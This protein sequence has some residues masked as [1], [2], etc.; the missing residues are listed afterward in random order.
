MGIDTIDRLR[1]SLKTAEALAV[2]HAQEAGR[3]AAEL[4]TLRNQKHGICPACGTDIELTHAVLMK[5]HAAQAQ[6]KL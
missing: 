5:Q 6:E 2:Q 3:L 4:D 1:A